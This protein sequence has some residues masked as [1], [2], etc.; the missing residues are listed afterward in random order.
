[1]AREEPRSFEIAGLALTTSSSLVNALPLKLL[2]LDSFLLLCGTDLSSAL[3]SCL[4]TCLPT[5]GLQ[6]HLHASWK[7]EKQEA[8]GWLALLQ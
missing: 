6:E 2:V 4:P 7:Q 3:P 5:L 1:M 8:F